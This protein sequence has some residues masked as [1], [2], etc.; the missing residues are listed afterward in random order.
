MLGV[1]VEC[2]KLSSAAGE[3]QVQRER[4]SH[5]SLHS[6]AKGYFVTYMKFVL[7]SKSEFARGM[8]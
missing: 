1:A 2:L 4:V 7:P 6:S 8:G 3:W 5:S